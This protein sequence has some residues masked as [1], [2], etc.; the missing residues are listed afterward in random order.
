[1]KQKCQSCSSCGMPMENPE[2]FAL[3]DTSSVYCK[4]CTDK[5]GKLLPFE[6]ILK[7]NTDYLKESQGLTEQAA[8]KMAT[9]LLKSQPAWKKAGV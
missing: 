6:K 5:N 8:L 7:A 1:M 3:G 9:D 4:Y 2:E